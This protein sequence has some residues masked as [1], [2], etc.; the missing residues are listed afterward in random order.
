MENGKW[1][2]GS[3]L[4]F[5]VLRPPFSGLRHSTESIEM[6]QNV[7]LQKIL[8]HLEETQDLTVERA[9]A[10]LEA[11]PAT[12][13][14]D[15]AQLVDTEKVQKVWGGISRVESGERER[16]LLFRQTHYV[17][18]KKAIAQEAVRLIQ[19]GDVVMIDGGTTTLEMAT[20][21]VGKRVRIITNSLLIANK[22]YT[23]QNGW[24]ATELFI[25]GGLLYP[26]S[27]L[28]VGPEAKK[29]IAQYHAHWAFLSCGGID[30]EG[31]HNTNQLVVEIEQEMIRQCSKVV[32]LAD[33]SKF[34]V[35]SMSTLCD[36]QSV[37]IIITD[38]KAPAEF[39]TLPHTE[40]RRV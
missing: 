37:D 35:K 23:E 2:T 3:Q 5:F 10:L 11:S 29:T 24:P 4:T 7:R 1:K 17:E 12:V 39:A 20:L 16:P 22:F 25:T 40:I 21:L 9:C 36:F 26:D 6:R 30:A 27:G 38:K 18:E 19:E 31:V 32:V 8:N 15:F 14:R 28:L 33:H 13:R 34:G